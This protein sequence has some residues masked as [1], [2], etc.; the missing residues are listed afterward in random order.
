MEGDKNIWYFDHG[1]LGTH[2]RV[3]GIRVNW[4]PEVKKKNKAAK[5]CK[6]RK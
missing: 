3:S 2:Y 4:Y 1:E 6:N 5:K